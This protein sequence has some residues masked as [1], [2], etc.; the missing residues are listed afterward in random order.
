MRLGKELDE[1]RKIPCLKEIID[2]KR[3][4]SRYDVR[5]MLTRYWK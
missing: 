3:A 5:D 4:D 1:M 2:A